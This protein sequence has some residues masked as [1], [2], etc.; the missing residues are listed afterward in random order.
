MLF[1]ISTSLQAFVSSTLSVSAQFPSTLAWANN[2]SSGFSWFLCS[3][4]QTQTVVSISKKPGRLTHCRCFLLPRFLLVVSLTCSPEDYG[5][6]CLIMRPWTESIRNGTAKGTS[7][8]GN[9]MECSM[10]ML[11]CADI[12]KIVSKGTE[13]TPEY[14]YSY[15]NVFKTVDY[16]PY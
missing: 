14:Q 11:L 16:I 9:G 6:D 1:I 8:C 7:L 2:H 10:C 5:K 3:I 4:H 15:L 13:F 12:M